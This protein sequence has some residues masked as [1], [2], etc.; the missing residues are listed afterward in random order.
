MYILYY[1]V[2]DFEYIFIH[3]IGI[4]V[5]NFKIYLYLS[6]VINIRI[7]NFKRTGLNARLENGRY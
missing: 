7:R 6:Y 1:V 2:F 3:Y 4:F 5:N